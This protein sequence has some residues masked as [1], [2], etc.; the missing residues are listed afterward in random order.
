MLT[1]HLLPLL[2]LVGLVIADGIHV[3]LTRKS[4]LRKR[5]GTIDTARFAKARDL[6][7]VK[8]GY[9]PPPS[10]SRKRA[11]QTVGVPIINSNVDSSY[12][13]PISIGTP[14][15]TFEV[16]LDTGSSDLWVAST[17]CRTCEGLTTFNP[18]QSS[19]IQQSQGTTGQQGIT[20]EYGSG[21]VQGTLAQDTVSMGGFTVNPQTFLV[22]ETISQGLLDGQTSGILGLA[23]Q[24]LASTQATPFWEALLNAGQFAQPEMSFFLTRF[25]GVD[26]ATDS[27]PGGFL[28]LGGTNSSL[29]TGNIEFL[30]LTATDSISD[31]TFWLLELSSVT[32]NGQSVSISTGAA[33]VS[34]IDT[35]TT[36]IGGPSDGVQAV[37]QAVP[38]SQ[39]LSG[40]MEGFFS[41]P[42][43][44]SVQVSLSFGGSSWPISTD[45]M[46]L[47]TVG[48]GTCVGGIFD[49]GLGSNISPGSGNPSWVVGDTFLKNVLSVFRASPLSVGFAQ[50]SSAA[51]GSGTPSPGTGSATITGTGLP[52]PA[53]TGSSSSSGGSSPTTTPGTNAASPVSS[54]NL[55][56]LS[57]SL[58]LSLASALC[59]VA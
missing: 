26:G 13:G 8:Y 34:A 50:L 54:L 42:C 17:N 56:G 18:S 10:N 11:G 38:N 41:F 3:P 49:L 14:P 6:L 45:D 31:A 58:V 44:T 20:I 32:V 15:Q 51:G 59:F 5:D 39:A 9:K 55:L 23:F 1:A 12:I 30:N 19:S 4:T 57:L 53:G 2:A 25:L 33:A 27:E 22:A 43:D 40:D 46:N 35:G 29:F 28:T 37:W 21:E 36:L 52:I 16:V 7:R 47:G 24:A 48:D